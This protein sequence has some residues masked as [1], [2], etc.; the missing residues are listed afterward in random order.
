MLYSVCIF[1]FG[2]YV[3]QEVAGFPSIKILCVNFLVYLKR[4]TDKQLQETNEIADDENLGFF[5]KVAK[6]IWW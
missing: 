2:V 5:E 3:G 4:V 1:V 6:L